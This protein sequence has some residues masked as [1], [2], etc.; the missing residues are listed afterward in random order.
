MSIYNKLSIN[1]GGGIIST[2]QQAKQVS[3]TATILIG[4]GGTGIDCLKTLKTE[5]YE[6]LLPD[7]PDA[8]RA[9][10]KHIRFIG[11]DSDKSTKGDNNLTNKDK[12]KDAKLS[13]DPNKE[14]FPIGYSGDMRKLFENPKAFDRKA[15]FSWLRYDKIEAPALSDQG[16]AGVRQI[17]R[18]LMMDKSNQFMNKLR[19]EIKNA[20]TGLQNPSVSVHIFAGL[21]GGTGSG[22]F[23]DVCYMTKFIAREVGDVKTY[24]YFFLPDVNLDRIPNDATD[25]RRY[26]PKNGY[27]AMQE[28]DY[29]MNLKF[30]GGS[31]MQDY[32]AGTRINW[33]EAPVDMCHLVCATNANGDVIENAYDYA[34]NV[35]TEYVMN[36]LTESVDPHKFSLKSHLGN[37]ETAV[38]EADS[39]KIIGSSFRY[40]VIGAS[41]ANIPLREINTYLA[42]ELFKEFSAI[43]GNVPTQTDVENL[44][45]AT[46]AKGAKTV[47]DIYE[48]LLIEIVGGPATDFEFLEA[49]PDDWKFVMDAGNSDMYKHYEAQVAKKIN[50]LAT[51]TKSMTTPDN[52]ESLIAKVKKYLTDASKDIQRGPMYA[53]G[54]IS[55]AEKHNLLDIIEGIRAENKSRREDEDAQESLRVRDLDNARADFENRTKRGFMDNDSKR[56][57]DYI[58]YREALDKHEIAMKRYEAIDRVLETFREQLME[59]SSE[60]YTKLCRVM[61]NLMDTFRENR[62]SL[63]NDKVVSSSKSYVEPM[64]TISELKKTLD[65]AIEKI[66]IPGMMEAFMSR[67]IENEDAWMK[68]DENR[69]AKFVND[70]FVKEAFASFSDKTITSYLKDKYEI[71]DDETLTNKVYDEWIDK[72]TEKAR[73]LFYYNEQIRKDA[74]TTKIAFISVPVGS[75]PIAKAADML[76]SA[77]NLW[78]VNKSYLTDRIFAMCSACALPLSAYRRC[79]EYEKAYFESSMP[80]RHYYEGRE[81]PGMKFND[82]TKLPSITPQS[83]MDNYAPQALLDMTEDAKKLFEDAL[84]QGILTADKKAFTVDETTKANVRS[85]IDEAVE[86]LERASKPSDIPMLKEEQEKLNGIEVELTPTDLIFPVAGKVGD[87][88][89]Q[90]DIFEDQFV[91]APAYQQTVREALAS[92]KELTEKLD[93]VKKALEEK[94]ENIQTVTGGINDY[95]DALFSGVI[96]AQ[97]KIVS[98]K[99]N[100]YGVENE[101]ILSRRDDSFKFNRI[102]IYQGYVSYMGLENELRKKIKNEA[103]D[104]IEKES[105]EML[106]ACDNMKEML[107]SDRMSGMAQNAQDFAECKEILDF[108]AKLGAS[109]ERFLRD[110]C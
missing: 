19:E 58:F 33:D 35:T 67:V 84:S 40:L 70:F 14:Y 68:E 72:L 45:M 26:I 93:G 55:A 63:E 17:G 30:N 81:I 32:G 3:N 101:T 48:S 20:K 75:G 86:K 44:A 23:L 71:T 106:D 52:E 29:C 15:E 94:A 18:F 65:D 83:L 97:G 2:K 37:F 108:I 91:S 60:Y 39:G 64:I 38:G 7:D 47:G 61:S 51:N 110:N 4:L 41:C 12:K 59:L 11:V 56:F 85:V 107:T 8:V 1:A 103:N 43:G 77:R 100:V 95:F 36:F 96:Q 6:R 49:Y 102:P 42:S 87:D 88:Q 73:P 57:D 25:I 78:S 99:E 50:I 69:I 90:R 76:H 46:M 53:G 109:F 104:R 80:G 79:S 21:S 9:E 54:M 82:W 89:L 16:A 34:M 22:T 62:D 27:A 31:F 74:D 92:Y 24:G 105:K 5:V 13:L 66:N 10:Y 98:Y 28:L